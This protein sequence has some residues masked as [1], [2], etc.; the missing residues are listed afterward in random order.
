MDETDKLAAVIQKLS[1]AQIRQVIRFAEFIAHDEPPEDIYDQGDIRE[2]FATFK[3]F[4]EASD[5]DL[6]AVEEW[7]E[8]TAGRMKPRGMNPGDVQSK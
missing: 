3:Q 1:P 2:R 5:V 4:C 8:A 7:A 6:S